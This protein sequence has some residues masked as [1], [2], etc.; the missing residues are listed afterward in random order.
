MAP[1][2]LDH[3]ADLLRRGIARDDGDQ[4][5]AIEHLL[6]KRQMHFQAV[7]IRVRLL[8]VFDKRQLHQ[9]LDRLL[10]DLDIAQRRA[11][12]LRP[13]HGQPPERDAMGRTDQHH[14]VDQMPGAFQA[15]IRARGNRARIDVAR[16]TTN[17]ACASP[18]TAN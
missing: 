13:A 14:S 18:A 16:M 3:L 5:E 7:F 11:E 17:T 12:R 6:Q 10:I 15:R 2:Q 4:L 8:N 9:R 1:H